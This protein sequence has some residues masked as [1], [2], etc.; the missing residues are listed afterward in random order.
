MSPYALPQMRHGS[1]QVKFGHARW[2]KR[3]LSCTG[4]TDE[5]EMWRELTA[6]MTR[7]E[8]GE[9][10]GVT[11]SAVFNRLKRYFPQ[12]LQIRERDDEPKAKKWH[13]HDGVCPK[14]GRPMSHY[15][16]TCFRCQGVAV[17]VLGSEAV[18]TFTC[19]TFRG[20]GRG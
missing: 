6:T 5:D 13:K 15:N 19:T 14:C 3:M 2:Q 4:Y 11:E 18:D 20:H 12:H 7:K 17:G 1:K 16:K 10:F 8:M 9:L